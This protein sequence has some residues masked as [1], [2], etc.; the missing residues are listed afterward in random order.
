ML[1]DN[2]ENKLAKVRLCYVVLGYV[3]FWRKNI[4]MFNA[5]KDFVSVFLLYLKVD[6]ILKRLLNP[7][8]ETGPSCS[9]LTTSLT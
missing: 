6:S 9:K 5:N 3:M 7:G 2:L 4:R 1:S 8:K